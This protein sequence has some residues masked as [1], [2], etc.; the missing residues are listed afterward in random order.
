LTAGFDQ[1]SLFRESG[2]QLLDLALLVRHLSF[3]LNDIRVLSGGLARRPVCRNRLKRNGKGENQN[4]ARSVK[5]F[6][7]HICFFRGQAQT[8]PGPRAMEIYRC[9]KLKGKDILPALSLD[10]LMVTK[11]L[12]HIAARQSDTE[13][14]TFA[15]VTRD[16]DGSF[17]SFQDVLDDRKSQAGAAHRPGTGFIDAVK[18]LE[19]TG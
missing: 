4:L 7:V 14:R 1:F 5:C 10:E 17:H 12:I 2:A 9:Q 13:N 15:E 8:Q 19:D 3:Q 11:P 6:I 18:P 16:R